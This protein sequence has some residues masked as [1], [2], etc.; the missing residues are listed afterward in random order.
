M[1]EKIKK[2]ALEMEM[3]QRENKALKWRDARF[4]GGIGQECSKQLDEESQ[5]ERGVILSD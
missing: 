2:M 5:S 3:L 4:E 1:K